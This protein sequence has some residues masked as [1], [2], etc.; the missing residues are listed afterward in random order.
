MKTV[1]VVGGGISGLTVA[2]RLFLEGVDVTLYESSP[3]AGGV[4]RSEKV[5]GYL[6]EHGPNSIQS[7]SRHLDQLIDSAGLAPDV[8]EADRAAARRYIVRNGTPVAAPTS[9]AAFLKT[10]LFS[11]SAKLRLLREPFIS[12]APLDLEESVAA[13]VERRL[14]REFL[15]YA[16]NPFVAGIYSGDPARLS[17][18]YAFPRLFR[19]EQRYGSLIRGMVSKTRE[20]KA[21]LSAAPRGRMISFTRG[22]QMLPDALAGRLQQR[23]R[24]SSRVRGIHRS[25]DKWVLGVEADGAFSE[26]AADAVVYAARLYDLPGLNLTGGVDLK[27]LSEVMHPPISVVA[28]GYSRNQID[29]PL[30]GFGLLV[31]EVESDFRILGALFSSTLF[32][33][34]APENHSLF[35]CFIGGARCP[36]LATAPTP[37]LQDL[38]HG[39]LQKLLGIRGEPQMAHRIL[40][41]KG[42]P[43]YTLGYGRVHETLARVEKA[44]PGLFLAGN[45]RRGISV[46]DTVDTAVE[47]AEKVIRYME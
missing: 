17:L 14:G 4:I 1:A 22:M 24:L 8:M 10:S 3:F 13:F 36:D 23:V 35:T 46:S 45:Y 2:F 26:H 19:L 12:P 28:L 43:Q 20:E 16:I 38:A 44:S 27:P 30:D 5:D 18:R 47:T 11:T 6:I 41:K 7:K 39:D 42:I 34:R 31:P 25:D 29:H 21:G 32:P 37:L 9:P 40:W 33:N 15:D